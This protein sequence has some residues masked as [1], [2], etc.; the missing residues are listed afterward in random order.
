MA[1]DDPLRAGVHRAGFEARHSLEARTQPGLCTTCHTDDFCENCHAQKKV[2]VASGGPSPHPVGW[3]GLRGEENEHGPAAWRDPSVC[4]A[5]HG[6]A[7]EQLCVGCHRVGGIGGNPHRP[8]WSSKQ[9]P[10]AGAACVG[11]HQGP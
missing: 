4:A 11:C 1:F 3:V 7:G 6:G 8:G 10:T 9:R 5:C 2:D